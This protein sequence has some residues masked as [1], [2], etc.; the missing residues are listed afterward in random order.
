MTFF[1]WC[2]FCGTALETMERGGRPRPTC[3][4]CSYVQWRNPVVGV[5]GILFED[6]IV[7][8][9]GEDPVR[10][11][12]SEPDWRFDPGIR[13]V[14]L[15]R[16]S[17]SG[18]WCIPCGY[19]EFDEEIREALAREMRE[20]TGLQVRPGRVA[21]V[22]SNFHD[23]ERPSVGVW[24]RAAPTGGLLRPGDDTEALAFRTPGAVDLPLAFPTD[25]LVLR[26]LA[27]R[28]RRS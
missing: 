9:L 15:A 28:S 7:R 19:V 25:G 3:P 11:A 24:F 12:V 5:A 27:R 20:E 6:E 8:V 1:R 13:R 18:T 23:P 2:P 26:R 16:R 22:R 17:G 21:A 4:D 10:R 14:L